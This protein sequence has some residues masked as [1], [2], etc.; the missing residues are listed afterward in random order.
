MLSKNF[1]CILKAGLNLSPIT[2]SE[3]EALK[4]CGA[5]EWRAM[6]DL[7]V[8]QSVAGVF[9]DGI[10]HL[11]RT[12]GDVLPKED[13]AREI[14]GR[15]FGITMQLEQRNRK[16]VAVMNKVGSFL[17]RYGCQM[18]VM[19]G[20]ACATMYPNP[21]HRSIG[22]ID[23]FLYND[24]E[25]SRLLK[26]IDP[27]WDGI[28]FSWNDADWFRSY[29]AQS[30]GKAFEN[31]TFAWTTDNT[32]SMIP[33]LTTNNTGDEGRASTYFV[34]NGSYLKLRDLSLGYSLPTKVLEKA[35]ITKTRFY[36]SGHNLLTLKSKSLTCKDP[37]N[38]NWAYPLATSVTFGVQVGF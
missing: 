4:C 38:P 11:Y 7:A 34:E 20:Q 14:K 18:M 29:W 27:T 24:Y 13:W 33:A 5:E 17:K 22:D 16:Q 12:Y 21:L 32:S 8:K 9:F 19:K 1:I 10:Q 37:E 25:K 35:K 15:L 3:T 30:L 6:V 31:N 36:V 23:C 28:G 2:T 26:K